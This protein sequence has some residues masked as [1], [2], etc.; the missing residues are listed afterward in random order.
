MAQDVG[1]TASW[2][3]G[4]GSQQGWLFPGGSQQE[5]GEGP[6]RDPVASWSLWVGGQWQGRCVHESCQ[7]CLACHHAVGCPLAPGRS[8]SQDCVCGA[9]TEVRVRGP[10]IPRPQLPQAA[11]LTTSRWG[12][13]SVLGE[14]PGGR[15]LSGFTGE[16]NRHCSSPDLG[17]L[18]G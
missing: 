7:V 6:P 8:P 5:L 11:V 15:F 13:L 4:V 16:W 3:A 1:S 2:V 9:S 18:V 12:W 14:L 10:Q 17:P